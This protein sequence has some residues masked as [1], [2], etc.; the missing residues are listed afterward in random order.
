MLATLYIL[1]TLQ[2][3]GAVIGAGGAVWAELYYFKAMKDGHVS[4]AERAHLAIIAHTLRVGMMLLLLSS[5]GLVLAAFIAESPAQPALSPSYWT[6]MALALLIITVSW[7]LS[8]NRISFVLG[9]AAGFTAWWFIVLL[10][11]GQMNALSF[12]A[13]LASYVVATAVIMLIL[14]YARMLTARKEG[15]AHT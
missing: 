8:R 6:E 13:S 1:A 3:T 10:A 12:G 5:I 7:A 15:N 2:A 11:L 4:K 9:S 14:S